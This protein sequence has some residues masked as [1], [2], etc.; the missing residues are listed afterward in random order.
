M[1]IEMYK[2]VPVFKTFINDE[3]P[4]N[5]D[6]LDPAVDYE[7]TGGEVLQNVY[8]PLIWYNGSS[9]VDLVP[10]LATN[11]PTIANGGITPDG[12]NYT[13][14]IRQGVEFAD[15]NL[16]TPTDVQ[17]SITRA[18]LINDINSPAWML[19]QVLAPDVVPGTTPNATQITEIHNS[20]TIN[21][22]DVV[23]HLQKVY[24]AFIYILA[25]TVSSVVEKA[26]VEAHGG[27]IPGQDNVWMETHCMGTGP[28]YLD[29]WTPSVQ[30]VMKKNVNYWRTPAKIDVVILRS[31]VADFNTR[32]LDLESGQ[33]DTIYVP[34]NSIG[35]V[36]GIPNTRIV[37]GLPTFDL[38]FMGMN[39]NINTSG[40]LYVGN[41]PSTFFSDVNVRLAFDHAFDC[42]LFLQSQLVGTGSS[43]TDVFP[44]HVRL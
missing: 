4:G 22:T 44:W 30:I 36:Y 42:A 32:L 16:M 2:A 8:E 6:T 35:S 15:G 1:T 24:P 14:H 10:M 23:F 18:M 37:A 26:Y 31:D 40:H 21:G 13:F 19:L 7:T 38:D 28:Y 43:L 11:V 25:F 27:V 17:Y 12:L 5:P 20:V 34:R 33:A 9:A 41:I 3:A 29:S 39:E